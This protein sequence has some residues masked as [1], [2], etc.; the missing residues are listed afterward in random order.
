M[1]EPEGFRVPIHRS[2]TEP[3]MMGG[4]PR[5]I[6]LINGFATLIVVMG[7]HNLLVLP[8]GIFSHMILMA[9]YKRDKHML[10]VIKTNLSRPSHLR[11]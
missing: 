10:S 6:A 5:H 1:S 9:L 4:I 7:A 2:L 8:V 3:L 11:S